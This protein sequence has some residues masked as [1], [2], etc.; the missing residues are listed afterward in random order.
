M[1][2][3]M[4]RFFLKIYIYTD[5]EISQINILKKIYNIIFQ[6]VD[7]KIFQKN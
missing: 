1:E 4:Y 5:G 3:Y 2:E 7:S 6:V